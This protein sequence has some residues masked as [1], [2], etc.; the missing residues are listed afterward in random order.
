MQSCKTGGDVMP[1]EIDW[2][3]WPE[4]L[5]LTIKG[6]KSDRAAIPAAAVWHC[7]Y[8]GQSNAAERE[9]CRGC[10]APRRAR[11][12]RAR[13]SV[14]TWKGVPLSR[15]TE[16]E[17][18]EM[19]AW[20]TGPEGW[21]QPMPVLDADMEQRIFAALESESFKD[22]CNRVKKFAGLQ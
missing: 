8:C 2:P 12:A 6:Y 19:A 16:E 22:R 9:G 3:V 7:A 4:A 20:I 18:D 14:T 21:P 5:A 17:R 10:Q 11:V 1:Y 13:E 15:L